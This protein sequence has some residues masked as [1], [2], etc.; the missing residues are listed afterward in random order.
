[1][2]DLGLLRE[3]PEQVIGLIK[4]KD[5]AYDPALAKATAGTCAVSLILTRSPRWSAKSEWRGINK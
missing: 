2:I 3:Q 4:R 5:P 1:M